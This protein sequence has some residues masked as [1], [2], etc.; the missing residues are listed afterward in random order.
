MRS[1]AARSMT[2]T[3]NI[4]KAKIKAFGT[5]SVTEGLFA[6]WKSISD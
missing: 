3:K 1:T 2:G 4:C 6:N 5:Y